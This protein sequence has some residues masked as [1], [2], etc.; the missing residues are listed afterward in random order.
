LIALDTNILIRSIVEEEAPDERT[1]REMEIARTLLESGREFFVP[2]SVVQETEWV[3]RA[4][5]GYGSAAVA[6]ALRQLLA[7]EG[8]TLDRPAAVS[9]AVEWHAR[10]M[11][12]SDALHLALSAPC[13]ELATFDRNFAKRSKRLGLRPP[14]S[15][16]A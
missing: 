6:S 10:G 15:A 14:V 2:V 13:A 9:Q 8:F 5:Y 4:C 3:L 11:D 16:P 1:A 12:F 7:T